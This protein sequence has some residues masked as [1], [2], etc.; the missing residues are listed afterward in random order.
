MTKQIQ[1]SP[2]HA[3][4]DFTRESVETLKQLAIVMVE[5]NKRLYTLQIEAA[6]AGFAENSRQFKS[7][8][9][10]AAETSAAL[11]QWSALFQEKAGRF[12]VIGREWVE[13]VARTID[14]MS[15]LLRQS[16]SPSSTIG[17]RTGK[18]DVEVPVERRV[19]ASVIFFPDRR[20]EVVA[21]NTSSSSSIHRQAAK[22]RNSA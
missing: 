18:R 3:P 14:E 21:K 22:K 11:E 1:P 15:E 7:L 10:S 4:G 6:H 12:V 8:L 9:N 13:I 17:Q 5:A 2:F 16:L 20:A 19:S